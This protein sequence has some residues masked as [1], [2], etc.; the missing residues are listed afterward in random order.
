MPNPNAPIVYIVFNRPRHTQETFAAIRKQKPSTLFVVADGPR[1]THP[2]DRERCGEV[3]SIVEA[4]DWPCTVFRNYSEVNLGCKRRVSTGLDWVFLH[5]DRAVILEDDCV[6]SPEFFMFCD[7]L[8]EYYKH[9]EAIWVVNGNSYQPE[10]RRGD[11]T[12]YF[13]KYPDC[14]GWA[15]W[16]RAWNRYQGDLPF[17]DDWIRSPRWASSFPLEAERRYWR[18]IFRRAKNGTIDTWDYPWL[19]CMNFGGGMAATPNAN[20]VKNIGVGV[21]GSH[22]KWSD[23]ANRYELSPLGGMTHPSQVAIDREADEHYFH[24]FFSK[25]ASLWQRG[26]RKCMRMIGGLFGGPYTKAAA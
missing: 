7:A 22:T 6:A 9:N 4:V 13:S 16:R 17:L 23:S 21:D 18:S 1:E 11:G 8:L 26:M 2:E 25:R 24:R 12:Y 10:H 5:V 20:L 15:T 19:A 14:W 3:R